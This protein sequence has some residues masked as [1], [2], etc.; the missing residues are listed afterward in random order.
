MSGLHPNRSLTGFCLL[1]AVAT[2][3]LAFVAQVA[4][5]PFYPGYSFTL[6]SGSMLG[7]HFSRQPWVF[8]TGGLL[9]GI[10]ALAASFGLYRSFRKR[11]NILVRALIGLSVACIGVMTMK[12]S[13]FPMPDPRHNSWPLLFD[14]M[15]ITPHLMLIG[16]WKKGQSPGLRAFLIF[17]IV[18]LLVLIP[19]TP[20]LGRG[21]LQRLLD[22]AILVPVGVVGFVFWRELHGGPTG[23]LDSISP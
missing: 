16:L 2:P 18:F 9:T 12:A 8:N 17:V 11:T 14:F 23:P 3:I 22:A 5:A 1:S 6:Q 7:T 15:L 10:A 13:L 19:L 4:A 20:W 21:T